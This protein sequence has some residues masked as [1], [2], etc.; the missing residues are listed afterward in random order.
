MGMGMGMGLGMVVVV[1]LS[2]AGAVAVAPHRDLVTTTNLRRP[3]ATAVLV[4]SLPVGLAQTSTPR[5]GCI[6][7]VGNEMHSLSLCKVV[8]ARRRRAPQATRPA[9]KLLVGRP[10]ARRD[11]YFCYELL[12]EATAV[13][14]MITIPFWHPGGSPPDS[15]ALGALVPDYNIPYLSQSQM[16]VILLLAEC[17]ILPFEQRWRQHDRLNWPSQWGKRPFMVPPRPA[18]RGARRSM[19]TPKRR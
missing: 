4:A 15:G 14:L 16:Q 3:A 18:D 6:V 7:E 19:R 13:V 1:V 8:W 11:A 9:R 12:V 10:V 17:S 5:A 2:V